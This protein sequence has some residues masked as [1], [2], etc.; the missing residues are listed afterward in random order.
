M[1]S[2]NFLI[3]G[4]GRSGTG[5]MAY[6]LKR[7]NIKCG[8]EI[9]SNRLR[10]IPLKHSESSWLATPFLG[11]YK[12]DLI[13]RIYRHP[14]KVIKSFMDLDR[15]NPKSIL[16]NGYSKYMYDYVPIKTEYSSIKNA[17]IYYIEWNKL[18]DDFM[19]D[20]YFESVEI[21]EIQNYDKLWLYDKELIIPKDVINR[22]DKLFN[23]SIKQLEEM[24]RVED[25]YNSVVETYEKMKDKS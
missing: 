21:D 24:L 10:S 25:M 19:G 5:Y 16:I 22:K 15:F 2:D 9:H 18:F 23:Y 7:N 17:A 14:L 1:K 4:C 6:L 13:V 3:T 20:E 8:H 11:L 12:D